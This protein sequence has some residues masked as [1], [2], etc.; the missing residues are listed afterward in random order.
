MNKLVS[1]FEKKVKSRKLKLAVVGMGYVGFPLALEFAEKK[2]DVT[3][4]EID[5][6]RLDSIK[7]GKSYITDIDS[8]QLKGVISRGHFSVSGDFAEVRRADAVLICVPTPLKGK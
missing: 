8:R 3:G 1:D 7:K 2:V 4:I 5:R 6:D